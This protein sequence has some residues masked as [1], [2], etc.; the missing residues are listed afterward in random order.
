[1]KS[2]DEKTDTFKLNENIKPFCFDCR[3]KDKSWQQFP[4]KQRERTFFDY[5]FLNY[6][7]EEEKRK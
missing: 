5:M 7:I 4:K 6:L 1:M 3:L 2:F